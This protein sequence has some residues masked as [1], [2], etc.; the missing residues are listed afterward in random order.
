MPNGGIDASNPSLPQFIPHILS[1]Q[2]GHGSV[3]VHSAP[4]ND[5]GQLR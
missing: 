1:I 5:A 3:G 4:R 2:G